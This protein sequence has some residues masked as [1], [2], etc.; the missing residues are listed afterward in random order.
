[1]VPVDF[2]PE[3]QRDFD[4]S[5]DWYA[6][7]SPQA[8]LRFANAVDEVLTRIATQPDLFAA[9]DER[10][11]GCLI[12]RFPFRVVYRVET[13]RVLIVAVAH[14]KRRPNYWKHRR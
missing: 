14:A 10:H 1:M 13:D 11:R 9:I 8:A 2:L 4:D 12:R 6:E 3:A 5:F 7:R